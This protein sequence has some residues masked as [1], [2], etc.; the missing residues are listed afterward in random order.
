MATI[1]LLNAESIEFVN[2]LASNN[3]GKS[4]AVSIGIAKAISAVLPLPSSPVESPEQQYRLTCS[5]TALM[6]LSRIN[7]LVLVDT[8]TIEAYIRKFY[9]ARYYAAHPPLLLCCLSPAT[10]VQDFFSLQMG[11]DETLMQALQQHTLRI[12]QYHNSARTL[13]QELNV[14]VGGDA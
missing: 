11:V 6:L 3:Q 4:L 1:S 14:T 2:K 10:A 12:T 7:E 9:L 8:T 13:I 5:I